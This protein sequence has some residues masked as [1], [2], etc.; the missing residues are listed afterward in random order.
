[1]KKNRKHVVNESISDKERKSFVERGKVIAKAFA[2]VGLPI[3]NLRVQS[4]D[5]YFMLGY[6]NY[7]SELVSYIYDKIGHEMYKYGKLKFAICTSDPYGDY[8]RVKLNLIVN[9]VKL[10]ITGIQFQYEDKEVELGM[11]KRYYYIKIPYGDVV[12][13]EELN[14]YE[15]FLRKLNATLYNVSRAYY[16]YDVRIDEYFNELLRHPFPR[17]NTKAGVEYVRNGK[18]KLEFKGFL[19]SYL[20]PILLSRDEMKEFNY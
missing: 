3:N 2:S 6:M 11:Y 13:L 17:I 12:I 5:L 16:T 19:V 4:D 8:M 20:P 15:Y 1:M 18:Y 10:Y 14:L 9:G 7:H